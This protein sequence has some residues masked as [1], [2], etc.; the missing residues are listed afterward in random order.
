MYHGDSPP[1]PPKKK[2]QD[3][4]GA[5]LSWQEKSMLISAGNEV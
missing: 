3:H 2:N 4:R 1:P 5:K